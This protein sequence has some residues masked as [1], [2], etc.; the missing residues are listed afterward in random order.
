MK[1]AELKSEILRQVDAFDASKLE[2]FY[3]VML[4]FV[5]S[6]HESDEWIGVSDLEKEGIVAA[7]N[8][9]ESGYGKSHT[10]VIGKLRKKYPIA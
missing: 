6:K 7:I 3:G 2:E 1:T 4:N 5:N 9:L 10:E 8:E